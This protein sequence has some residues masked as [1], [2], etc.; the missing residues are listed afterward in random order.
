MSFMPMT[1][2]FIVVYVLEYTTQ[3]F[4]VAPEEDCV[5]QRMSF[6]SGLDLL[7]Y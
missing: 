4:P 5:P 3:T 2:F 1:Q 6:L 7:T